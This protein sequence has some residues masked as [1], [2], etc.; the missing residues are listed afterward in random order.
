MR[1]ST[2]SCVGTTGG[3]FSIFTVLLLDSQLFNATCK[4]NRRTVRDVKEAPKH[5]YKLLHCFVY[6]EPLCD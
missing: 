4:S 5:K 3:Y 6:F 1:G 2:P